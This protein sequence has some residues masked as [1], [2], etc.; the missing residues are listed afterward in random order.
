[1]CPSSH[2]EEASLTAQVN[3]LCE[4]GWEIVQEGR[5]LRSAAPGLS[6]FERVQGC[7][8][9]RVKSGDMLLDSDTRW[10]HLQRSDR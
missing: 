5:V 3:A 8:I 9:G 2:D 7:A 1:M 6:F 4:E 10:F